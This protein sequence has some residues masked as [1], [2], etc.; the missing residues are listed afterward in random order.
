[1]KHIHRVT[2]VQCESSGGIVAAAANRLTN[3]LKLTVNSS[4]N[5][6]TGKP[7]NCLTDSTDQRR[8]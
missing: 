8:Q 6:P 2:T 3:F 5:Q 7:T 1:M 4:I